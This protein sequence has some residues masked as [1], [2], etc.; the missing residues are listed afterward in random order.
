MKRTVEGID[1]EHGKSEEAGDEDETCQHC[2]GSKQQEASS[3]RRKYIVDVSGD[4]QDALQTDTF[5][6]AISYASSQG[7]NTNN[8]HNQATS[9]ASRASVV[10]PKEKEKAGKQTGELSFLAML[11]GWE[12]DGD[13]KQEIGNA[14]GGNG[15]LSVEVGPDVSYRP[16]PGQLKK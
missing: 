15:K 10:S 9:S 5:I 14:G 11:E 8:N 1:A 12:A 13:D 4:T 16:A 6:S 3:R 7:N 2:S